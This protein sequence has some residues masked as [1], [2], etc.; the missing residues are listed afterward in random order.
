M[1][2][3]LS[4][5][6]FIMKR[7]KGFVIY[8]LGAILAAVSGIVSSFLIAKF[9][10]LL[11]SPSMETFNIEFKLG[12]AFILAPALIQLASRF[13]R[14]GYMKNVLFDLRQAAFRKIIKLPYKIFMASSKDAYLSNLVNDINQFEKEFFLSMLNIIYYIGSILFSAVLI[15]TV[16]IYVCLASLAAMIVIYFANG[17]FEKETVKRKNEILKT[18]EGFSVS[19]SNVFNGLEILKLNKVEKK[20]FENTVDSIKVLENK[21][22]RYNFFFSIQ[23]LVNVNILGMS[24]TIVIMAYLLYQVINGSNFENLVL[25][26]VFSNKIIWGMVSFFPFYNSLK[27][28]K[29]IYEKIAISPNQQ[30]EESGGKVFKF[31]EKIEVKNLSFAFEGKTLFEN[32]NFTIEKGKKYLLKGKSGSG[33]TT[34]I[35]ILSKTLDNY[36]GEIVVDGVDLRE[37][38]LKS[39]NEVISFVYQNV[40]LFEDSIRENITLYKNYADEKINASIK[41]A[42]LLSLIEKLPDGINTRVKENGKNFS[43]GERQ[44]ISIARA[45]IRDSQILFTDEATSSLDESLGCLIEETILALDATCIS[46]SHRYYEGISEKYD[47]VLEIINNTIRVIKAD[48][49]FKEHV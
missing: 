40:F 34:L 20:F 49:Y 31:N 22:F 13:M 12:V 45:I 28:S 33:K 44:R 42:G 23:R 26:N 7:K 35:N 43:G 47:Y 6:E 11:E 14:I 32:V 16:D 41:A 46:I 21:K 27:A 17:Y 18:S 15:A 30:I 39:F 37:I 19:V 3:N 29:A 5:N 2:K 36:N 4:L 10:G 1:E 48:E 24:F 8:V 38:D 9:A 25:L